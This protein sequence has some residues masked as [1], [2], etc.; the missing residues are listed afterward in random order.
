MGSD[1]PSIAPYGTVF[2]DREQ[3]PFVLAAGFDRHFELLWTFLHAELLGEGSVGIPESWV[4]NRGRVADREELKS[5][6]QERFA[7]LTRESVLSGCDALKIP[8]GA[9][10]DVGEVFDPAS[11]HVWCYTISLF[12]SV[13][14]P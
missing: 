9:V 2:Y 11:E 10:A 6:L 1:H 13:I 7:K 5:Y 14:V 3:K 12:S 4:L 8:A